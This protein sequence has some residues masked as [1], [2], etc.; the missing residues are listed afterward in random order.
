MDNAFISFGQIVEKVL[1]FK[2]DISDEDNGIHFYI[3][4][5]E[6]GTQVELDI[7][8][9]EN[10]KVTIGAIPPLYRVNTS[11]RPSYHSITLTAKTHPEDG[12]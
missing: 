4:E 7:I 12:N 3:D 11:F 10:G 9:D 5:I 6:V 8:V 1:D 2:G